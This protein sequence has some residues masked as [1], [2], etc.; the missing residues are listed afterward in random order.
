MRKLD[1]FSTPR[2]CKQAKLVERDV[3]LKEQAPQ[4]LEDGMA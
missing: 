4:K 1:L 2:L 3:I